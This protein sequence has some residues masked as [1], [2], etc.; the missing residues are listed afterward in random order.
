MTRLQQKQN[1]AAKS[2]T[3]HRIFSMGGQ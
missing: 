3:V 1:M 2:I